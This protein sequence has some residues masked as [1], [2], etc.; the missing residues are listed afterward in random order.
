MT[1]IKQF[2]SL[3]ITGVGKG[4][5]FE[6]GACIHEE[7]EKWGELATTWSCIL[8]GIVCDFNIKTGNCVGQSYTPHKK[9]L[10]P[11][12]TFGVKGKP[13]PFVKTNF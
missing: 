1:E 7:G 9:I 2:P 10:E 3:S 5:I 4:N 11:K 6:N 12:P 8:F 13:Y